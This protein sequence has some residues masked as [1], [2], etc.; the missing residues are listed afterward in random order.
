MTLHP[1]E[2]ATPQLLGALRGNVDKKKPT[3]DQG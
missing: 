2:G 3:R 1:R